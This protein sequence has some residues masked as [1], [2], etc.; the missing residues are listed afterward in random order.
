MLKI[1]EMQMQHYQPRYKLLSSR[2]FV[3]TLVKKQR[4]QTHIHVEKRSIKTYTKVLTLAVIPECK[5]KVMVFSFAY[6]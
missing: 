5:I 2:H 3:L 1:T 6:K 4:M